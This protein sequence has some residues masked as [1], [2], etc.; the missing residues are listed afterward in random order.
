MVIALYQGNCKQYKLEGNIMKGKKKIE[1]LQHKKS[2]KASKMSR[3]GYKSTYAKKKKF[4]SQNGGY[5][6]QYPAPKPWK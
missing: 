6:F 3:P 4:L 5:G 2:V 1:V